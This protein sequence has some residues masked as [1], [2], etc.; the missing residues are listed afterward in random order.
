MLICVAKFWLRL[1][2]ISNFTWKLHSSQ[3]QRNTSH[4]LKNNSPWRL[5]A[6]TVMAAYFQIM[7]TIVSALRAE[8]EALVEALPPVKAIPCGPGALRVYRNFHILRTGPG[9]ERAIRTFNNYLKQFNPQTVLMVGFA[10]AL[11]PDISPGNV[12]LIKKVIDVKTQ[13]ELKLPMPGELRRLPAENLLTVG[14]S[15]QSTSEKTKLWQQFKTGLVD[16]ETFQL[17][18]LCQSTRM[19]CFVIKGVTDLAREEVKEQF[20]RNFKTVQQ[21]LFEIIKPILPI[22]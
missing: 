5:V 6:F 15:V 20:R 1:T 4:V 7:L 22:K 13:R 17:A 10:G 11:G 9:A 3:Y 21:R 16:M 8:F 14:Q 19:E 12:Y 2:S 18:E